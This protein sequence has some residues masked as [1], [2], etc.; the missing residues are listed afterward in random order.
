MANVG[1]DFGTHQTKV[2]IEQG[3]DVSNLTY[4]FYFQG[5]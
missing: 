4:L 5:S 1:L 3:E 2:C